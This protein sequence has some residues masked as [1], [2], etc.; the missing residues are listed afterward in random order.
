MFV[1]TAPS[2]YFEHGVTAGLLFVAIGGVVVR[3]LAVWA[4]AVPQ[5]GSPNSPEPE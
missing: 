1:W 5:G 2:I 4:R 3:L